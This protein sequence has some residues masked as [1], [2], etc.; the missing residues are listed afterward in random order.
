MGVLAR[1]LTLFAVSGLAL[2]LA[3]PPTH[4]CTC[5]VYGDGSPNSMK[6]HAKAVYIGEALEVREATKA[7]R[8]E[9]SNF[10]IVR[11]RVERYWKGIKSGEVNVETDLTGCGPNLRVGTKY[12]VYGMGKRLNTSCTRTRMLEDAE[13]DLRALGRPK[14]LKPK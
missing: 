11:M 12:L 2:F 9:Y 8:E 7:E 3:S 14:E 10:Y 1:H 6:H 5:E 4:A 13:K